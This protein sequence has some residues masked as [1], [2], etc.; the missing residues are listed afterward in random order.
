MCNVPETTEHYLSECDKFSTQR[1]IQKNDVLNGHKK[2]WDDIRRSGMCRY[3]LKSDVK[4]H[5]KFE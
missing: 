3:G 2:M 1:D 4:Q 5:F